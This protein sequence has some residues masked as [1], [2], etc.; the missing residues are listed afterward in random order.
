MNDGILK[1]FETDA[2]A[3]GAMYILP[4]GRM[5]DLNMFEY[6]HAE[7]LKITDCSAEYLKGKGWIRLNTKLKYIELPENP[8]QAQQE[9]LQAVFNTFGNDFQ[10][11]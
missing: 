5:L 1:K 4:D 10:I 11:K 9:R 3:L 7:F 6:G 2:V 8:T